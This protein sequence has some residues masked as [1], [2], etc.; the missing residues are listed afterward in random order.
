MYPE[1]GE[2]K[3]GRPG[4]LRPSLSGEGEE[5]E[6]GRELEVR[7]W[8]TRTGWTGSRW[9]EQEGGSGISSSGGDRRGWPRLGSFGF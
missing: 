3:D 7:G 2:E 5:L 6:Q 9:S 8:D 4:E 1:P